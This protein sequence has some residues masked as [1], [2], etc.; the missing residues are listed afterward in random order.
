[1]ADAQLHFKIGSSFDGQGFNAVNREVERAGKTGKKLSGALGNV[2][3]EAQKLEGGLGKVAG[4]AGNVVNGF[5]QMGI[6]GGIVA[7]AKSAMDYFFDSAKKG[8]DEMVAAAKAQADRMQK[9]LQQTVNSHIGEV[10]AAN[11]ATKT[12]GAEAVKQFDETAAAAVRASQLIAQT[13]IAR[14]NSSIAKVQ[15]EKLN[16]II[17]E[18]TE[19]GKQLVAAKYDLKIAEMKA[20]QAEEQGAEKVEAARKAITTAQERVQKA[21]N[22]VALAEQALALARD[23]EVRLAHKMSADKSQ[24]AVEVRQAEQALKEARR[25]ERQSV[26]GVADAEEK[27]KATEIGVETARANQEAGILQARIALDKVNEA[28]RKAAEAREKEAKAAEDAA[29]KLAAKNDAQAAYDAQAGF[30]Q[31]L[32]EQ[33]IGQLTADIKKMREE[34]EQIGKDMGRVREGVETDAKVKNGTFGTYQYRLDGN[35][36]PDNFIDWQ[37]AMRF[38]ERAERDRAAREKRDAAFQKKMQDLQDKL[39]KRG[40]K[41]LSDREKEALKRWNEYQ[42]QKNGRE[43][44]EA[45]IKQKQLAIERIRQQMAD[46]LKEAKETLK[47]ALELV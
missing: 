6:I 22:Q 12:M 41:A 8:Y 36:N 3:A 34:V 1:M 5:S 46:D 13:D 32:G 30:I 20:A 25:V 15:V 10:R 17:N 40:E 27:L 18:E 45:E 16:A 31:G 42:D 28:E 2:L 9:A 39:D 4:A 23:K 35:D 38:A 47:Q 44:R 37:R 19:A 24:L 11:E 33:Q 43:R 7:G 29:R 26:Q 21:Q 14:A